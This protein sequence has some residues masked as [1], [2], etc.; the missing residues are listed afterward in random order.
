MSDRLN[1][2]KKLKAGNKSKEEQLSQGFNVDSTVE[3][4][5]SSSVSPAEIKEITPKAAETK[6]PEAKKKEESKPKPIA[7]IEPIKT[8]EATDSSTA[9]A[10][11]EKNLGLRLASEEDKRYLNMV[12]LGRGIT[13]KA[14]F[15]ELMEKEFENADAGM[16]KISDP[17]LEH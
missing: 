8:I 3:P 1:K 9:S 4:E 14:F 15:V 6:V 12:P 10:L 13:K 16:I 17:E 7:P 11:P 2:L 5:I